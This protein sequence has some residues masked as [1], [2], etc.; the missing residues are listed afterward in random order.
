MSIKSFSLVATA[1][2]HK[3][4]DVLIWSIRNFYDEPILVMCDD[5]TADHLKSKGHEDVFFKRNANEDDIN[6]LDLSTVETKNGFHKKGP[7]YKKMEALTW[8]T[9]NFG[10]T[11]FIDSDLVFLDHINAEI[12]ND[13]ML[14][15][16]YHPELR[17][18]EMWKYGR[19]NAGY[20]YTAEETLGEVWQEIYLTKSRFYEQEGMVFLHEHFDVGC[21]SKLHNIGYWRCKQP[22]IPELEFDPQ[23]VKSIHCH[24]D[25]GAYA[26]AN[27]GLTRAYDEWALLWKR[28]LPQEY[29]EYIDHAIQ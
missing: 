9:K 15:P 13:V 23:F 16:H 10:N 4:A 17:K 26:S 14:S 25:P 7:I 29:L 24:F 11:M 8:A 19:Y 1:P 18:S 27:K 21:F 12:K 20:V 2:C 3:E 5:T 28:N 22:T 6:Q